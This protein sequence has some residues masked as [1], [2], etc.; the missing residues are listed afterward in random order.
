M[1]FSITRDRTFIRAGTL[2]HYIKELE[3]QMG[4]S[5]DEVRKAQIKEVIDGFQAEYD[6]LVGPVKVKKTVKTQR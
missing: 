1:A 2:R 4:W 6:K 3:K 5:E